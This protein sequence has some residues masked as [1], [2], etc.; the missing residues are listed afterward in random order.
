MPDFPG[1]KQERPESWLRPH[2]CKRSVFRWM[3]QQQVRFWLTSWG[4]RFG[5]LCRSFNT[6]KCQDAITEVWSVPYVGI[7]VNGILNSWHINFLRSRFEWQLA[8]N[9]REEQTAL[10]VGHDL[11]S[12]SPLLNYGFVEHQW[13]LPMPDNVYQ[14]IVCP[15]ASSTISWPVSETESMY[16]MEVYP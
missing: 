12:I 2:F 8:P 7:V 1:I 3:W 10:E 9:N 6:E 4:K 14:A 16:F 15:L 5:S 13:Q 11:R